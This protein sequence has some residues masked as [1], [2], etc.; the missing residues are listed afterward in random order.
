MSTKKLVAKAQQTINAPASEVWDALIDPKKIKEYMFGATVTS[1]WKKGSPITW[2]GEMNGKKYEDKGVILEIKPKEKLQ[3]SHYSPMSGKPDAP[4]NYHTVT[5][6]LSDKNNKTE[7]VLT[8][9]KNGSEKEQQ[10]SQKNW[11]AMLEGLKKVIE[12]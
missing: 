7:V 11:K 12:K 5:I 4:E 2:K 8:Q 9:D 6:E 1:D 10:E 3:Y